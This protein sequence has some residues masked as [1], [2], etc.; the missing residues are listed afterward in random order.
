MPVRII[1]DLNED[2]IEKL[3]RDIQGQGG[4][5]SLLGK[6]QSKLHD[7]S[8]TLDLDEIEMIARYVNRYGEGGFQGRLEGV[9]SE[10]RRLANGLTI[11]TQQ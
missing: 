4:F 2:E 8:L 5:Q 3:N 10:L 9:L 6:L 1:F 7:H 11:L